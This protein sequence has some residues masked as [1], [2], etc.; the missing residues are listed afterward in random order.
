MSYEMRPR[1]SYYDALAAIGLMKGVPMIDVAR[2]DALISAL[3]AMETSRVLRIVEL[4][5]R[6]ALGYPTPEKVATLAGTC[7][8]PPP[9]AECAREPEPRR[10]IP[11]VPISGRLLGIFWAL[12]TAVATSL[13]VGWMAGKPWLNPVAPVESQSRPDGGAAGSGWH[14]ERYRDRPWKRRAGRRR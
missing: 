14:G 8:S 6:A 13:A 11:I 10:C 3:M 2:D 5:D 7:G 9:T 4:Y 1:C 12:V